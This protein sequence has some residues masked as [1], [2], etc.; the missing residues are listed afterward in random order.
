MAAESIRPRS[1]WLAEA[2]SEGIL[3]ITTI[4]FPFVIT[5]GSLSQ[6]SIFP[7]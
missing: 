3:L 6:M 7:C 5:L 4:F 2:Q 1:A